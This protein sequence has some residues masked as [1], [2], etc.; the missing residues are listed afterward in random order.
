LGRKEGR[1]MRLKVRDR[2]RSIPIR[3]RWMALV[4]AIVV[5]GAMA[6]AFARGG[7]LSGE[8]QDDSALQTATVR[9]GDLVLLASGTGT[10]M[11]DAT[12]RLGFGAEGSVS[13]LHVQVGDIVKAGDVL[14]EQAER[15]ELEAE[16]AADQL[17]LIEAQEALVDL[18]NGADMTRAEAQLALAQAQQAL[19]DA[20]R[21][22]RTQQAGN[23]ASE[24]GVKA[25]KAS[26]VVARESM[27]L[28]EKRY[29]MTP[30]DVDDDGGKARAFKDYAAAVQAYQ[31]AK[32][33]YNW[34]TGAP[35]E[36]Q[37]AELDAEVAKAQAD[38]AQA[39]RTLEGVN[40]GPNK[41]ELAKA[42]LQVQNAEAK[43]AESQRNLDAS[44]VR[45]PSAGTILEITAEVG[46][47]VASSFI[48]LADLSQLDLE[49]YF[50]ETDLDK[51]VLGNPVEI[52]FDALPDQT[53]NG[54]IVLVDPVLNT[55]F[56]GST[57][58]AL[59]SMDTGGVAMDNKILIG[60]N[61]A[62]DVIAAEARGVLL[63]PIEA[64]REIETGEY[65]VFV[66]ENGVPQLRSVEVGLMDTSFAEIKSGLS[67][68]EVVTTGIV[69]TAG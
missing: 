44:I 8:A 33:N 61:A 3:R 65:G 27:D 25:A 36:I 32:I 64:L 20:E 7:V 34:Y 9:S 29:E 18:Q 6:F 5:V 30:G 26:I 59:T 45:A 40:D 67:E 68:G 50:D 12:I 37:Q 62:V 4:A 11:A 53:F 47:K 49:G 21:T 69:E 24:I 10:L 1:G 51:I 56:E 58:R 23:R 28:A 48:K 42:E 66:V 38:V 39:Q 54:E 22:W 19:K 55:S 57:V 17:A 43:A 46:D 35:D 14:A 13:A 41:T 15:K 60:M 52:V 16:L 31:S 2:L 63:V